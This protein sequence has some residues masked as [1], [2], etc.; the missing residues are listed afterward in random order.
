M[1]PSY[2]YPAVPE[3]LVV[4]GADL[5]P[6]DLDRESADLASMRQA[7]VEKVRQAFADD[8]AGRYVRMGLDLGL[9]LAKKNAAYG[10][11]FEKGG[12]VLALLYPNGIRPDQMIDA[13]AAIRIVDKL[14]RIATDRDAFG[15]S[16]AKD[17]AGY[18]ILM[19]LNHEAH[20]APGAK[21]RDLK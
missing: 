6:G 1:T 20:K 7:A 5:Q 2:G 4:K 11:S 8:P 21:G 13:L 14:F 15:E 9:L 16:P 17:I 19:A 12:E 18:A 10:N 3:E